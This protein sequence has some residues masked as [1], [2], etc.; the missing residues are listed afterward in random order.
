MMIPK[1]NPTE[2]LMHLILDE[3]GGQMDAQK[4]LTMIEKR[5]PEYIKSSKWRPYFYNC[6]NTSANHRCN[7]TPFDCSLKLRK[8]K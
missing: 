4:L 6:T 2:E 3:N 5:L 7:A 8:K 1:D